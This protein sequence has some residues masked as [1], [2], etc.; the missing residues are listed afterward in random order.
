MPVNLL[1]RRHSILRV[2]LWIEK[3]FEGALTN[4][5]LLSPLGSEL[6]L[7]FLKAS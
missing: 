7:G 1:C 6:N 3:R 4:E 5:S 2:E